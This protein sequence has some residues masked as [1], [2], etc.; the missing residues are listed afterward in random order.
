MTETQKVLI[1][2]VLTVDDGFDSIMESGISRNDF[3]GQC[4]YVWTEI[5]RLYSENIP[6]TLSKVMERATGAFDLV[7]ECADAGCVSSHSGYYVTSILR[8]TLM[9]NASAAIE[10]ARISVL[11]ADCDNIEV[12]VA[13]IQMKLIDLVIEKPEDKPLHEHMQGF[14]DDCKAGD[15]GIVPWFL[16][17]LNAMCGKLVEEFVVLHAQPSVGK[18][19][20]IV[21]WATDLRRRGFNPAIAT[22]ESSKKSL[23]QRFI[24]HLGQVN[25]LLMKTGRSFPDDYKKAD[26]AILE[27]ERLDFNVRDGVM[28][29]GQLMA[30]AKIQKNNGADIIFIDNLRHIDSIKSFADETRKFMEISLSVK[31]IRDHI[32]IPVIL[33]HHSNEDGDVGWC[34]DIKKDVDF[35][36]Y[37]ER[38]DNGGVPNIDNVDFVF[39]KARDAGT[40]KIRTDFKKDMQ[41][42]HEVEMES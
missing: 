6:V 42:Y 27:A 9:R 39:Q 28:T 4:K 11:E 16:P 21:Q 32:K 38:K 24:S 30:W 7:I 17:K 5:E 18:T 19:A 37:L 36:I 8:E 35:L 25:T 13:D 33:L 2:Y 31:R 23:A 10:E 20:F 22:L 3:T 15:Y 29:D 40:F 14:V 12:V 26:K 41:T 1:G 34:K